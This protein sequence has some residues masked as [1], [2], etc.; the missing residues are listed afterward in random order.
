MSVSTVE[1]LISVVNG[2]ADNRAALLVFHDVSK[3]HPMMNPIDFEKI[4]SNIYEQGGQCMTFRQIGEYID[5][6]KAWDYI[7]PVL[8]EQPVFIPPAAE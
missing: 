7:Y 5:P 1:K 8:P 4:V 2:A 3:Y 6:H